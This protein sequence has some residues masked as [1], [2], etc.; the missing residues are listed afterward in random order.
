M[1]DIQT[2]SDD[3]VWG[4][5]GNVLL[6]RLDDCKHE[7]I[8]LLLSGG[9]VVRLYSKLG[10]Y[11]KRHR[12]IIALGQVDERFQPLRKTDVNI[13]SIWD[14]GIFEVCDERKIP[15]FFVSQEG[16][17][18]ESTA[19]YNT[20]LEKAFSEYTY[21]MAVLGLGEDGHTAGLLPGYDVFWDIEKMV[22]GYENVGTYR[23]RIT[24]TPKAIRKLDYSLVCALGD[25]KRPVIESIVKDTKLTDIT[26]LPGLLL[27]DIQSVDLFTDQTI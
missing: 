25:A 15:Y 16:Y 13:Q 11:L 24:I 7:K 5:A 4:T 12:G 2:F 26:R 20:V 27:R 8:L 3:R 23:K 22:S 18:D 14:T 1:I 10:E 6:K 21:I 9:S 19:A 17:L